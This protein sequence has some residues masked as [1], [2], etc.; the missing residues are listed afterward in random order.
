MIRLFAAL[1][2]TLL[3]AAV[4]RADDPKPWPSPAPGAT[5]RLATDIGTPSSSVAVI[6]ISNSLAPTSISFF[7]DTFRF[8][9][10]GRVFWRGREVDGDDEF[11]AAMVALSAALQALVAHQGCTMTPNPYL[12]KPRDAHG[13]LPDDIFKLPQMIPVSPVHMPSQEDWR[14]Y[15]DDNGRQWGE[16]TEPVKP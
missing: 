11:K 8:D 15:R 1:I 2:L 12:P 4:A 14:R 9:A 6:T 5:L 13:E 10:N 7:G 16:S 3:V